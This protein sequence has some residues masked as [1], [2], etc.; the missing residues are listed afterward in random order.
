MGQI[1]DRSPC[2]TIGWFSADVMLQLL[3]SHGG[4]R[5]VNSQAHNE[6]DE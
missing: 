6:K 2:N 1:E 4:C 3:T 5:T